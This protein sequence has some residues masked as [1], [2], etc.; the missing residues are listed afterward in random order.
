MQDST[1]SPSSPFPVLM[2]VD[3]GRWWPG[4]YGSPDDTDPAECWLLTLQKWRPWYAQMRSWIQRNVCSILLFPGNQWLILLMEV[5]TSFVKFQRKDFNHLQH[6]SVTK[7]YE[8]YFQVFSDKFSTTRVNELTF[9]ATYTGKMSRKLWCEFWPGTWPAYPGTW[10][11]PWNMM[12]TKEF[13]SPILL[14]WWH[15]SV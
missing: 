14:E 6:F 12:K 2:W 9:R 15:T 7:S 13:Y 4:P 1:F 5:N 3:V 10:Y 8:I 11:E